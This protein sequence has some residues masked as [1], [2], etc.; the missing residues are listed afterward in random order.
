[1][2]DIEALYLRSSDVMARVLGYLNFSSGVHDPLFHQGLNQ[3]FREVEDHSE[4]EASTAARRAVMER[5]PRWRTIVEWL[6]ES[7][8]RLKRTSETFAEASQADCV[9]AA[10][11]EFV[12]RFMAFHR[13]LLFHQTDDA[14]FGPFFLGR[15][16]EV[17]LR[18]KPPWSDADQAILTALREFNDFVGYRPVPTL[19][20]QRVEPRPHE[21]TRPVPLYLEQAGIAHGIYEELVGSA[22]AIL[23]RTDADLCEAVWFQPQLLQELSLDVRAYDFD[24]PVNKRPN[25]HFGEWDPHCIDHKGNY[26]RF[27][28]REVTLQALMA[29][30]ADSTRLRISHEELVQEAAAVLAGTV[31]MSSAIT[32]SGPG[33]HDSNTTLVK[34]IPRIATCRDAFYER[35]LGSLDDAHGERLRREAKALHQPFGGARQHLNL[36]LARQRAMQLERVRLA[37]VFARMGYLNAAQ[38]QADAV[39]VA[40]ARIVC[41]IDCGLTACYHALHAEDLRLV[42]QHLDRMLDLLHRGIDC[43]AII[44]PWNILGF[45]AQFSLFPALENSVRDHRVDELLRILDR[46]FDVLGRLWSEAAAIDDTQ[47]QSQA[48]SRFE[49]LATWWNRFAAHEVKSV[50]TDPPLE[51]LRS[52]R[53]VA[54]AL[55]QWKKAGAATGDVSFWAPHVRTFDSPKPYALVVETLLTRGDLVSSMSLLVHWLG[56][57]SDVPLERRAA[58]FHDLALRW[59]RHVGNLVRREPDPPD[60]LPKK[61]SPRKR[62]SSSLPESNPETSPSAPN[63]PIVP[64]DAASLPPERAEELLCKFFDF[65]E[66]NADATW[67]VPSFELN[68]SESSRA[69]TSSDF[70]MSEEDLDEDDDADDLFQAA[71]EDVVYRGST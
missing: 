47:I 70:A 20:W 61:G 12:D 4:P 11:P 50:E 13:D 51:G 32:G 35:L 68:S 54:Q 62:G 56:K 34:L 43:G 57:S 2:M 42:V 66:A 63:G 19:E 8:C 29:R 10:V 55:G 14:L 58:S 52:A 26:R 23:L 71:Y 16:C 37:R 48:E 38:R 49:E 46:L 30:V 3:L 1:M 27:V 21:W 65:L 18:Q 31:L 17:I 7:L 40:S 45:D 41:R 9:L 53:G 36:Y 5:T 24:H 64:R 60:P 33:A 15:A 44:D 25:Y 59:I 69:D 39:P 22:V 28:V 67:D 6:K